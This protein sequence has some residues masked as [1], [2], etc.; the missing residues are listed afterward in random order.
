[1]GDEYG[2]YGG[3]DSE[4]SGLLDGGGACVNAVAASR[5][6]DALDRLLDQETWWQLVNFVF[7][8]VTL[9][10]MLGLACL[11][12]CRYH[13]MRKRMELADD[14]DR[15]RLVSS[16]SSSNVELERIKPDRHRRPPF[17]TLDTH[18]RNGELR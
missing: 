4:Y 10:I 17:V 14:L 2:S 7:T 16:H 8:A 11:G 12:E 9:I 18:R 13:A 5:I 6:L 15:C 3:G 1:M